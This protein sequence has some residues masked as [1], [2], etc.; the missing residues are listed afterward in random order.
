MCNASETFISRDSFHVRL[1][2]EY[3]RLEIT[4]DLEGCESV[5]KMTKYVERPQ[6]VWYCYIFTRVLSSS[7]SL[8]GGKPQLLHRPAWKSRR[9]RAL[10]PPPLHTH[11]SLLLTQ[12]RLEVGCH[13]IC[14]TG[15][16]RAGY[17]SHPW[18]LFRTTAAIPRFAGGLS[19][20]WGPL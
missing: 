7:I 11:H 10:I 8:G 6:M 9:R 17:E 3:D 14:L 13:C 15:W 20:R 12:S 5:L 18:R 2:I 1:Q 19:L 16:E 4:Y